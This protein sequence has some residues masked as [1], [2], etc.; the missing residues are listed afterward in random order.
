MGLDAP[1]PGTYTRGDPPIRMGFGAPFYQ[2]HYG[3]LSSLHGI[4]MSELKVDWYF[5][6]AFF[7]KGNGSWES[8]SQLSQLS[9][10]I[11]AAQRIELGYV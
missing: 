1:L 10:V 2:I 4:S 6:D 5:V 3:K 9:D 8:T 7:P 11:T